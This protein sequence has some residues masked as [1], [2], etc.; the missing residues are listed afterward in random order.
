MTPLFAVLLMSAS[1]AV[2][3]WLT[4]LLRRY[5]LRVQLLDMPN[6]RSSHSLPTPRGGGLAVVIAFVLALAGLWWFGLLSQGLAAATGIGGLLIAAISYLD[7]RHD[8]SARWRFL[9]H[10]L[11]AALALWWLGGF[12]S[13]PLLGLELHF[14]WFGVLI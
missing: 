1:L 13:L 10:V 7:D 2:S 4:G 9:V 8:V 14:G 3:A 12:P 5:A 11:A 6:E